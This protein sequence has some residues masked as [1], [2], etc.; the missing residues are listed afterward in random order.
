RGI[1]F[2][3]I[4][5]AKFRHAATLRTRRPSAACGR[6]L[7]MSVAAVRICR[8]LL[9]PRNRVGAVDGWGSPIG[10][11]GTRA[12]RSRVWSEPDAQA[13]FHFCAESA[14]WPWTLSRWQCLCGRTPGWG[15]LQYFWSFRRLIQT[16]RPIF[17][18]GQEA[19]DCKSQYV[20]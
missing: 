4:E 14:F 15:R 12:E 6:R 1:R 5:R 11:S 9:R 13:A 2:S 19:Q 10:D 18:P 16:R 17:I 7:A 8:L 20:D 3:A